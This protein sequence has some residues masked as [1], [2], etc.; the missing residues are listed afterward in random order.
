MTNPMSETSLP[1]DHYRA[2]PPPLTFWGRIREWRESRRRYHW[3]VLSV[4]TGHGQFMTPK[5]AEAA[6][7]DYIISRDMTVLYIDRT[8]KSVVVR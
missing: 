6:V 3:R 7:I 2:P 5:L 4:S 8:Y 1:E